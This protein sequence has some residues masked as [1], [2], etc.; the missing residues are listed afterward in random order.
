MA[1]PH[2]SSLS[3]ALAGL[4]ARSVLGSLAAGLLLCA[5]VESTSTPTPRPSI[6]LVT[7]DTLRADHLGCYGYTPY[8][9]PVSPAIDGL[10]AEGM[11]FESC[12]VPRGQTAP[13]LCSLMLGKYPSTHG[14]REN[15]QPFSG[16]QTT[17][18][19]HLARAGYRTGAFVSRLPASPEGHPAQGAEVFVPGERSGA[20][21]QSESD[22][23]VVS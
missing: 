9:K 15:G 6:L 3:G 5:C 7:I 20:K 17:L 21:T 11:L 14:V 23:F 10:A 2:S 18:A 4:E 13:S 19:E 8:R 16:S 1:V 22:I 12:F